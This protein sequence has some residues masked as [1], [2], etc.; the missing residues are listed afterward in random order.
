MKPCDTRSRRSAERRALLATLLLLGGAACVS[1]GTYDEDMRRME[2]RESAISE[3][4]QNQERSNDA[5]TKE[6]V[7]L[8]EALEDMRLDRD[9]LA[10]DVEKLNRAREILTGHLRDRDSQVEELSQVSDTYRGLVADLQSEVTSGQIEIEQLRDGIRLN[11]PQSIL[12][13]SGSVDLDPR[14]EVVLRKVSG[15]LI[16]NDYRIEVRGHSDDRRL[17]RDLA[18][19]FGTNWE[20]AAARAASVVR[21]FEAEGIDGARMTAVSYGRF[22]PTAGNETPEGR[23]RN[24]RIEIRLIPNTR[25]GS[26]GAG[27]GET[28]GAGSVTGDS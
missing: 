28:A 27:A 18:M 21:L 17:V 26:D 2:A 24:R 6:N 12:F 1:R 10:S 5:L 20:L 7:Q 4:L 22:A 23:A 13:P 15:R 11:L 19:R 14:G 16:S 3:R 25:Q 9:E 8:S